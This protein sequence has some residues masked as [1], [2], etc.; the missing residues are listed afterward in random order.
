[1]SE[2]E[3]VKVS[4]EEIVKVIQDKLSSLRDAL[5]RDVVYK[6]DDDVGSQMYGK[7][8]IIQ[9]INRRFDE[10]FEITLQPRTPS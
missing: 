3:I 9:I 2:E 6:F 5:I 10:V 4:E 1:M 8:A 7:S